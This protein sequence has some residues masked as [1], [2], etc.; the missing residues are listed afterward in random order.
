[1]QFIQSTLNSEGR[2]LCNKTILLW[3]RWFQEENGL[4][5]VKNQ[6]EVYS[7]ILTLRRNLIKW[8]DQ[9]YGQGI[10]EDLW[11]EN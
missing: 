1:M 9:V 2:E 3:D 10:L 4:V 5:L 6:V 8:V 11:I 7:G